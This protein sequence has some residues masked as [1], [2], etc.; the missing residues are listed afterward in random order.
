MQAY[1]S[2]TVQ[3]SWMQTPLRKQVPPQGSRRYKRHRELADTAPIK[4][5]AIIGNYQE[6]SA[7]KITTDIL[8]FAYAAV[9][10]IHRTDAKIR[11]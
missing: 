3:T 6:T 5:V 9:V 4:D 7:C 2:S 8:Y 1:R 11:P 10:L